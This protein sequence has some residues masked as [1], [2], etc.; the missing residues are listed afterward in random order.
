[1][2]ELVSVVIPIYNASAYI[3]DTLQSVEKQTYQEIEVILVD[4]CSTDETVKVVEQYLESRTR[5]QIE[6]LRQSSNQGVA[7]ARNRGVALAKGKY[8]AFLDADD[9]WETT[10]IEKQVMFVKEKLV[11]F[12]CTSYEYADEEGRGS[13][14]VAHVPNVITYEQAIKN[15]IIFTSTVLFDLTKITKEQ[16]KMPQI[17]SE[18]TATWWQ[19]LRS[20]YKAYGMD[21]VLVYYRRP[22]NSLSSNKI[23][24]VKRI[25]NLYRRWEQMSIV[26]STYCFMHY[27]IRTTVRRL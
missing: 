2:S 14:K 21:E 3:I 7:L 15:T 4:D 25:W 1:M 27:A 20:G 5:L 18:D 26:K 10:K 17:E 23:K 19:I 8:L 11:A 12:V 22:T 16:I 24:A 6:L 13:G 9:L